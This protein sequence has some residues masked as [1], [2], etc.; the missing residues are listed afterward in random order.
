[1]VD[2]LIRRMINN[3]YS[4]QDI[5]ER[6]RVKLLLVQEIRKLIIMENTRSHIR[7]EDDWDE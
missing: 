2:Q 7:H 3:G 1:M 6:L 4:D 5:V